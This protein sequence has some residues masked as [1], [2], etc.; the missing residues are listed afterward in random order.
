[1]RGGAVAWTAGRVAG[2]DARMPLGRL[3]P[4]YAGRAGRGRVRRAARTVVRGV[5]LSR[6]GHVSP[7]R[8]QLTP[9]LAGR[10]GCDTANGRMPTRRH[11]VRMAVRIRTGTPPRRAVVECCSPCPRCRSPCP[12]NL[13]TPARPLPAWPGAPGRWAVPVSDGGRR[14]PSSGRERV[15]VEPFRVSFEPSRASV[16]GLSGGP[17][18]PSSPPGRRG[19]RDRRI[20]LRGS[21]PHRT[22]PGGRRTLSPS[23]ETGCLHPGFF[24]VSAS[25]GWAGVGNEASPCRERRSRPRPAGTDARSRHPRAGRERGMVTVSACGRAA[26]SGRGVRG[27]IRGLGA[28]SSRCRVRHGRPSSSG[29]RGVCGRVAAFVVSSVS[30][31]S[32][33]PSQSA[34]AG[35]GGRRVLLSVPYRS[36]RPCKNVGENPLS[37]HLEGRHPPLRGEASPP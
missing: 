12:S 2:R 16:E 23:V 4:R 36:Q 10:R 28:S 8:L 33:P 32:G 20:F 34:S 3:W 17:G 7:P 27:R 5:S 13:S 11:G 24:G 29:R 22:V 31:S 21:T 26:W 37:T 1:V 15:S 18:C 30:S 25:V 35:T 6:S 19:C 9:S 14:W